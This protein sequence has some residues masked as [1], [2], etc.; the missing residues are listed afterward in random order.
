MQFNDI[1]KIDARTKI[2]I[3]T[4]AILR[5]DA[6]TLLAVNQYFGP[7]MSARHEGYW[8]LSAGHR[9]EDNGLTWK[10]LAPIHGAVWS[11]LFEHRGAIYLMGTT[12]RF[13]SM[14][15]HRSDDGG[16]TWTMPHTSKTGLIVE[17]PSRN[18]PPNFHT[19]PVPVIHALGVPMKILNRM[20]GD[21]VSKQWSLVP[22]KMQIC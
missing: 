13:G 9:S 7:G 4:P 19:S 10:M 3:G 16:F 20:I 15:I 5:V 17:A 22:L 1:Y 8:E 6:T 11:T 2:S 21:E 14:V 12:G 18:T